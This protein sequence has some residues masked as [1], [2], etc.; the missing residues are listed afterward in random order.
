MEGRKWGGKKTELRAGRG[1]PALEGKSLVL[2]G[3]VDGAVQEL[4]A[5]GL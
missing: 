1:R 2:V 3:A 5:G 4:S